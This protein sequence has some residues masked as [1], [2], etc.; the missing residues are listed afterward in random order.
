MRPIRSGST[1]GR[2]IGLAVAMT[3]AGLLFA[4]HALPYDLVLLAVPAWLTY[5]LHREGLIADP[6]PAWMIVGLVL[7]LDLHASPV[8]LTPIALAGVIGWTQWQTKPWRQSREQRPPLA[9]AG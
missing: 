8:P 4:P 1:A 3:S 5:A 9:E 7:L 6:S 2:E